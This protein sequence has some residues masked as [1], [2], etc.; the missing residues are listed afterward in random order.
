MTVPVVEYSLL[1]IGYIF[2][3]DN[4][5][6]LI[7]VQ[8]RLNGHH[9]IVLPGRVGISRDLPGSLRGIWVFH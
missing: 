2:S 4:F 7:Q 1:F 8:C 9:E 6:K 3:Q 5:Q